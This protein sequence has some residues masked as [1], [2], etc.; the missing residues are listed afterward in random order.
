[1][2][3]PAL[4]IRSPLRQLWTL[5]TRGLDRVL[6]GI[7]L[8][9]VIA[10]AAGASYNFRLVSVDNIYDFRDSLTSPTI[11]NYLIGIASGALLPFAFA[12][13]V[14]QKKYWRAGAAL[15]LLLSFYPVVL[16]KL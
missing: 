5:S 15:L 14:E 3:L 8:F 16:S 2:L 4:F 10:F 9:A 12:C 6:D 7:L 1:F 11:V 13:F